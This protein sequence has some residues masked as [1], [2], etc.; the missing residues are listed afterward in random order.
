MR[1]I[2]RV[3]RAETIARLSDQLYG[4]LNPERRRILQQ[5]LL[6]EESRYGA[7]SEQLEMAT[8]HIAEASERIHQQHD[9]IQERQR[10]GW[11]VSTSHMTLNNFI[12]IRE[13]Y[14]ILRGRIL[15]SLARGDRQKW[16]LI[17]YDVQGGEHH[18]AAQQTAS[19]SSAEQSSLLII[20]C[21]PNAMI[22]VGPSG[23]IVMVNAEAERIFGYPRGELLG[24]S[25]EMLIPE[26]FRAAHAG[27]RSG[28]FSEPRARAMGAGRDLYGA[29][30]GW[31]RVSGRNRAQSHRE[32]ARDDGPRFGY[33]HHR[34]QGGTACLAAK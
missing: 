11:D 12:E 14:E 30:Q 15:N 34:A 10:K 29:P 7:L 32:R 16:G 28:Y 27:M 22:M 4:E 9:I 25:V 23:V 13:Q 26:R 19:E 2:E 21:A 20:E 8:Q 18:V 5:T 3:I 6:E 31:S 17:A 1:S 24:R 33:R